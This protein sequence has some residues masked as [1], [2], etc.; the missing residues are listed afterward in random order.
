MVPLVP[1]LWRAGYRHD[2]ESSYILTGW[3][4][5]LFFF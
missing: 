3:L 1:S 5:R 2:A 4:N